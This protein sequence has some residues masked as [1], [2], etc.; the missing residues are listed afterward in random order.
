MSIATIDR[1][2]TTTLV[3]LESTI[4]RG[5][6]SFI[7]VGNALSAIANERL[8]QP[9]YKDFDEYCQ[10]RWGF[11]KSTGYNYIKSAAT[12]QRVQTIGK[13]L[14]YTQALAVSQ[15]ANADQQLDFARTQD[16]EAMPTRQVQAT[17]SDALEIKEKKGEK[18]VAGDVRFVP[19]AI[20][21]PVDSVDVMVMGSP[22]Y[23]Y[24]DD[25]AS[26]RYALREGASLLLKASHTQSSLVDVTAHLHHHWTLAIVDPHVPV[27]LKFERVFS[28][29]FP[30]LWYTK[31]TYQGQHLRDDVA[32]TLADFVTR[33]TR[34]GDTVCE[35]GPTIDVARM[36]VRDRLRYIGV[37]SDG[38]VIANIKNA[39]NL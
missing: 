1:P 12:A 31:G 28:H 23:L 9:D 22:Y 2:P 18:A 30:V 19:S 10:K 21:I 6:S 11:S 37:T 34:S 35:I 7:E 39:L 14:T 3:A 26:I 13:H 25:A 24:G 8:Y 32:P 29:W 17:V 15:I 27:E 20:G 5:M 16:I 38:A 36:A 4:E 33:L